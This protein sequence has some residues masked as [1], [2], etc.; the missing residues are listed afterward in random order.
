MSSVQGKSPFNDV[1]ADH[2]NHSLT[3]KKRDEEDPI[4]QI[5]ETCLPKNEAP[6]KKSLSVTPDSPRTT[7]NLSGFFQEKTT[8]IP[9]QILS[10]TETYPSQKL[11]DQELDR[12]IHQLFDQIGPK[13]K[14][15]EEKIR[16]AFKLGGTQAIA[17]SHHILLIKDEPMSN[18]V[19]VGFAK[20]AKDNPTEDKLY[21][22]RGGFGKLYP[23]KFL[24][25][26]NDISTAFKLSRKK[27][28]PPANVLTP[29]KSTPA[30]K[31]EFLINSPDLAEAQRANAKTDV[32][33]E[34]K[35]RTYIIN[36]MN[37]DKIDN[38]TG[39]NLE[40][41]GKITYQ[42]QVLFFT[43]RSGP[44]AMDYYTTTET[45][46]ADEAFVN[47]VHGEVTQNIMNQFLKGLDTLHQLGV[48]H[49]DIK[50]ANLV[51]MEEGPELLDLYD[52][53]YRNLLAE[54]ID[55]GG[56]A[57]LNE[58]VQ[59][60]ETEI[61]PTP[62][63]LVGAGTH[64]YVSEKYYNEVGRLVDEINTRPSDYSTSHPEILGRIEE[65]KKLLKKNDD[66]AAGLT[67]YQLWTRSPSHPLLKDTPCAGFNPNATQNEK[68]EILKE[69]REEIQ[70]HSQ[71]IEYKEQN[72]VD[73][74]PKKIMDM[75]EAGLDMSSTL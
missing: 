62:A 36:K 34:Y 54:I 20:I 21:F 15:G 45:I 48:A 7:R 52:E 44:N 50:P 12:I 6:A 35:M 9:T 1:K 3:E 2:L 58:L 47:E 14:L 13:Y 43:K 40:A 46:G 60:S 53:T 38:H 17:L 33:G 31:A 8:G 24:D 37:Q 67:L 59:F 4:T 64:Q 32:E 29:K 57:N 72:S 42:D 63:E 28:S 65:I 74:I 68:I 71:G 22:S 25:D 61:F 27:N 75:I 23:V 49:R 66:F 41:Y 30:E 26:P 56:A 19:R 51:L 69:M 18:A 70:N 10:L 5:V 55:F 16:Q 73:K 11:T 39:L